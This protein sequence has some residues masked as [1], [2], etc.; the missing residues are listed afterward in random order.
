MELLE[1]GEVSRNFTKN[2]HKFEVI[3]YTLVV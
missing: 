2:S 1:K 3:F